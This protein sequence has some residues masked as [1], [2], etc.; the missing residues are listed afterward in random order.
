MNSVVDLL[1]DELEVWAWVPCAGAK[2]E[3]A[4]SDIPAY[5]VGGALAAG[6]QPQGREE[7]R[8]GGEERREEGAG[9]E[10]RQGGHSEH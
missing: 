10:E 5:R 8:G 6:D 4:P 2:V 1:L 7:E 3:K 9:E